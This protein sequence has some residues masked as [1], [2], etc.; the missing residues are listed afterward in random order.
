MRAGE[1]WERG[2]NY[3]VGWS[4]RLWAFWGF[5]AIRSVRISR[6][7][8]AFVIRFDVGN[9]SGNWIIYLNVIWNKNNKIYKQYISRIH[10]IEQKLTIVYCFS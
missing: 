10:L 1:H 4:E 7:W 6:E 9:I 3:V 2:R 8:V 5:S